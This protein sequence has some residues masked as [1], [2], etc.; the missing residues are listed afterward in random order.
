MVMVENA[1]CG[2]SSYKAEGKAMSSH[3]HRRV[4]SVGLADC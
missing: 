2:K 3:R 4:S 1:V